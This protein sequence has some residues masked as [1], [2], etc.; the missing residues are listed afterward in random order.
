MGKIGVGVG[1]EFPV[2]E[3]EPKSESESD[4]KECEGEPHHGWC[5]ARDWRGRHHEWRAH[6]REWREH[7]REQRERW[8]QRFGPSHFW[9]LPAIGITLLAALIFWGILSALFQ[10]PLMLVGLIVLAM[11]FI[12][13]LRYYWHDQAYAHDAPPTNPPASPATPNGK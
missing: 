7:W 5:D 2:E 9:L 8:H 13:H 10:H 11:L 4:E 3:P 6:D 12:A 1:E